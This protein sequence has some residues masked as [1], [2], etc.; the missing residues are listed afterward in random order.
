MFQNKTLLITGGTGSLGTA[1]CDRLKDE[2]L[3][4]LILLSSSEA[5][6]RAS[7]AQFGAYQ[8]FR[9]RVGNI[10]DIDRLIEAFQDVDYIIHAAAMKDIEICEADPSETLK[11]NCVGTDNVIHAAMKC[12]VQKILMVSTD[13]AVNPTTTYGIS[14]AMAERLTLGARYIVGDKDIKFSVARYGN[15]V[16][17]AGS[18][19]P[20]WG[21]MI[22]AGA[23]SL[24]I[25]DRR[26]TRFWFCM[27]NAVDFVL[28]SLEHMHGNEV[29]VPRIPSV[30]MVD[31]AAAFGYPWHETGIREN[32][33]IH[34]EMTPGYDSGT[35]DEF[36]TV[37]QIR[38]TIREW[39][40]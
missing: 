4:K 30:R 2:P 9:W 20:K 3:R 1:I 15:V 23:K 10:R 36:L 31:V 17:S 38:E 35:N 14:K 39:L 27:S 33:K 21:A 28:D 24:P 29:F 5:K 12:R 18:V 16:G 34:E 26:M 7:K 40:P 32:E 13:K 19:V 37:E 11:T 8:Q 25:T 22:A 6:Q